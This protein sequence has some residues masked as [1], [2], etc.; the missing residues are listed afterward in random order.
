M[1][2]TAHGREAS[3][4]ERGGGEVAA[5]AGNVF[6]LDLHYPEAFA[7]RTVLVVPEVTVTVGVAGGL[8]ESLA[9]GGA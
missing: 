8:H 9:A 7:S 5:R 2:T 4:Y 6:G 1:V 3:S